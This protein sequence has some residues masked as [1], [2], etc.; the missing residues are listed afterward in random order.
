MRNKVLLSVLLLSFLMTAQA[1]DIDPTLL[2]QMPIANNS[3]LEQKVTVNW[4]FKRFNEF[5]QSLRNVYGI[6]SQVIAKAEGPSSTIWI[7]IENQSISR[8]LDRAAA[9]FGY[10]WA[11]KNNL[12]VFSAIVPIAIV[13]VETVPVETASVKISPITSVENKLS[14]NPTN[15]IVRIPQLWSLD[16]KDKTLRSALSKW[17]ANA[18]WQLVWNVKA[19]YPITNLWHINGTFEHAVNEVLKASQNAQMPLLATMHD[20]NRVLEIHSL[21]TIVSGK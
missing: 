12:V 9:R 8:L 10:N 16:P 17:C 2:Y 5:T 20:S 7:N 14:K 13:P 18:K 1:E 11:Y 3:V 15:E 4:K 6:N 19:D 21:T